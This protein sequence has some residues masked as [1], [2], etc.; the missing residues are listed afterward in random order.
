MA[1]VLTGKWQRSADGSTGWADIGG[2]TSGTYTLT[3]TDLLK[4]IR[5]LETATNDDGSTDQ[6]SNVAGPI[7]TSVG[8]LVAYLGLDVFAQVEIP[9]SAPSAQGAANT[10]PAI[11]VVM[12]A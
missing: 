11:F 12:I 10:D 8:N 2:A 5:Y 6:A 3:S 9:T 1:I 4:Y 7:G